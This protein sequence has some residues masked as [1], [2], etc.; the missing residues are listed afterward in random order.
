MINH[1]QFAFTKGKSILDCVFVANKIIDHLKKQENGGLIFKV[2]VEKAFDSV[3]WNFL[4][5]I[6]NKLGFGSR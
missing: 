3:D 5:V 2:D 1:N 4:N 6:M